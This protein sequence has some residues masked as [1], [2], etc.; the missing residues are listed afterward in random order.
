MYIHRGVI[1]SLV[2]EL[3]FAIAGLAVFEMGLAVAGRCGVVWGGVGR[4]GAVWGGEGLCGLC[5]ALWGE[6]GG[7]MGSL[8]MSVTPYCPLC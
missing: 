6:G 7:V 8:H 3:G 5:G 4:L 1:K 2:W